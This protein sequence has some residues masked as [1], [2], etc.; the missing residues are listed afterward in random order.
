MSTQS[1]VYKRMLEKSEFEFSDLHIG[2]PDEGYRV[3]DR[4][5][6]RLRKRGYASFRKEGRKFFWSLSEDGK[7]AVEGKLNIEPTED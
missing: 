4:T 3:A 2:L 1:K 5:L 7:A 6:Q